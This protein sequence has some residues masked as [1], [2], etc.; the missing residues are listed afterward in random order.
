MKPRSL[1]VTGLWWKVVLIAFALMLLLTVSLD[2]G[3]TAVEV[4]CE[5]RQDDLGGGL[6]SDPI[7]I[8]NQDGRLQVFVLGLD[9]AIYSRSELSPGSGTWSNWVRFDAVSNHPIIS[10]AKNLDGRIQIFYRGGDNALWHISQTAANSTTWTPPISLGG[11]LTSEPAVGMNADG[12]LEV[13]VRGTDNS[14]Y[15]RW[16]TAAGSSTWS[17]WS[18]LGGQMTSDPFVA[19]NSDG[20][21]S[22]FIRGTDTAAWHLRQSAPNDSLNWSAWENLGGSLQGDHAFNRPAAAQTP[23]GRLQVFVRW[24]DNTLRT[25]IQDGP[26]GSFPVNNWANLWGWMDATLSPPV[27]SNN[28]MF[29]LFARGPGFSLMNNRQTAPDFLQW[30]GF[31]Y[32]GDGAHSF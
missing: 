12:R 16:Q 24:N 5:G 7:A 30:S 31:T 8:E 11:G 28:G 23:D 32:L 3:R 26:G 21:L 15:H 18:W 2:N 4:P 6:N 29:H 20:R 17:N 10:A 14:L 13:F 9:N 22:V 27:R 1:P 25:M 19:H